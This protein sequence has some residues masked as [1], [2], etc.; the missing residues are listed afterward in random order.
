[1]A[2]VSRTG[3]KPVKYLNGMPYTGQYIRMISATDN[4][5]LGDLVEPDAAGVVGGAGGSGAYQAVGR[6]ETGDPIVG[7]VVGWE[8]NPDALGNL[9]HSASATRAVFIA[10]CSDLILEGQTTGAS[11]G[12]AAADVGLNVNFVVAAGS[13]TTGASNFEVN[14]ATEQTTNTLDLRIV[15]LVDRP[16]N[17]ITLGNMKVLVKVNKDWYSDQVAGV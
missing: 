11:A 2:N 3:F 9:Y 8:F 13:T 14:D 17:D 5:F 4:L 12:L 15:G 16:D 6:A 7:V 1:M 10:P